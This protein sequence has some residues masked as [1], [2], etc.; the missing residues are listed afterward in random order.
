M[1]SAFVIVII[2]KKTFGT[3]PECPISWIKFKFLFT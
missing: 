1:P 3:F 2:N